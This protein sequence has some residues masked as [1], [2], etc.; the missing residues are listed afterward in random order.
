MNIIAA[1]VLGLLITLY[2]AFAVRLSRWWISMPMVFVAAGFFLGPLGTGTFTPS[3]H[4]EGVRELTEITL[5]VLLFADASTLQLQQLRDDVHPPL[6]LLTIGLLLSI[7]L[8][9]IVALGTLPEGLALA[10]L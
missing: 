5:A 3:L 2:A 1:A 10:A 7:A 8:G 6:R 9:T 4:A